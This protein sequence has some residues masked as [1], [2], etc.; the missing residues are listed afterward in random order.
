MF[1]SYMGIIIHRF[2]PNKGH[3]TMVVY[4]L[5]KVKASVGNI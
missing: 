4:R 5:T 3:V 2:N 1:I